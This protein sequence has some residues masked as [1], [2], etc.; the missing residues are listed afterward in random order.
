[1][2]VLDSLKEEAKKIMD[3]DSAHD[4]EHVMRVYKNAKKYAKKK[5]QMRN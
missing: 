5:M 2:S 1:M 4:F 3:G